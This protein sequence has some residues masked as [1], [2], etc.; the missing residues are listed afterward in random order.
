M[1][2]L[3]LDLVVRPQGCDLVPGI[4]RF[5][6][7]LDLAAR[8]LRSCSSLSLNLV[9]LFCVNP[10]LKHCLCLAIGCLRS[11]CSLC[12]WTWSLEHRGN[13]LPEVWRFCV[14]SDLV[15]VVPEALR[16]CVNVDLV[17]LMSCSGRTWTVALCLR[18]YAFG[19]LG[20]GA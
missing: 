9:V 17:P 3:N 8:C 15:A 12:T 20:L 14:N 7:Y 2:S 13:L 10:R 18:G 11:C 5:F 4:L 1:F 16:F 6:V 19:E